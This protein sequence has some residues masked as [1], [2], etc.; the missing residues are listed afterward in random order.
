MK[1]SKINVVILGLALMLTSI[2][3]INAQTGIFRDFID[4]S[5]TD[6][7]INATTESI[8]FGTDRNAGDWP[9]LWTYSIQVDHDSISGVN[10]GT[11]VLQVSN[12]GPAETAEWITVSTETLD[13]TG[14]AFIFQGTLYA[15]RVRLLFTKSGTG[16]SVYAYWATFKKDQ[17]TN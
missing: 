1:K 13:G 6:T 3:G 17:S 5:R 14:D 2:A 8:V 4:F 16:R 11:C 7:L 12:S 9:R 10:N 15:R